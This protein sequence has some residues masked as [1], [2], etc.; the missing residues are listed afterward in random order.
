MMYKG[1]RRDLET[2]DSRLPET[3][4]NHLSVSGNVIPIRNSQALKN[5][6]T[7]KQKYR[8]ACDLTTEETI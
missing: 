2:A 1:T 8:H 3:P 6:R 4:W 5:K 7:F